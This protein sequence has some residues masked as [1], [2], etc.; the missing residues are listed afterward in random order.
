M[1]CDAVWYCVWTKTKAKT[2]E[3]WKTESAGVLQN[4]A[5]MQDADGEWWRGMVERTTKGAA[6]RARLDPA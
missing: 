3:V 1:R 4:E 5:K 2:M 6:A